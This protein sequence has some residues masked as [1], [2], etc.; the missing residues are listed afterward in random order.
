MIVVLTEPKKML[1][2]HAIFYCKLFLWFI[3]SAECKILN[4]VDVGRHIHIA[5][6]RG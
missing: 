3:F 4:F 6:L 2:R 1:M 5:S